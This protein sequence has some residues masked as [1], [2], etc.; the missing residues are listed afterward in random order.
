YDSGELFGKH[1]ATLNA[2]TGKT[3]EKIF[4]QIVAELMRCG[5]WRGEVLARRKDGSTFWSSIVVSTFDHP[6]YGKVWLS[7]LQDISALKH[8]E[9]AL[10]EQA[11]L[12]DLAHDAIFASDLENRVKFW[13]RGAKDMYGW[14]AEEAFGRVAYELL[15][16][17][18]PSSFEEVK[19]I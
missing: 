10:R 8:A 19:A 16:T 7:I 17:R 3:P 11:A 6:A 18:F 1:V 5:R 4:Q 14:S 12:L 15:H 2:P 9:Q 13:N